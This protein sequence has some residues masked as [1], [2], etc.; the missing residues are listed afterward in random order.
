VGQHAMLPNA[1]GQAAAVAH[2]AAHELG[3]A[4][5]A[6][7]AARAAAP[8]GQSAAAG[9]LECQW[10]REQLLRKI[11][12]LVLDDQLLRT[13]SAG[14]CLTAE[15]VLDRQDA[16]HA[17]SSAALNLCPSDSG[18]RPRK[19]RGLPCIAGRGP[20]SRRFRGLAPASVPSSP[21]WMGRSPAAEGIAFNVRDHHGLGQ[22]GGERIHLSAVD[23]SV[24]EHRMFS[25]RAMRSIAKRP[26]ISCAVA[27]LTY[28]T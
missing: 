5:Y 4:A 8:E 19:R 15:R 3:A 11:R 26:P 12:E 24:K 18:P 7:K 17:A 14:P 16:T 28:R 13:T 21:A 1:A 20:G 22:H 25:S 6:I 2:V 9:Q 27:A 23:I 10:Q